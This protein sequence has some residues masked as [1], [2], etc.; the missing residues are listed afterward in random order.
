VFLKVSDKVVF[1]E[2]DDKIVLI[3]LDTGFYYSLNEV[4]RL[5]FNEIL[6]SK[7]VV[8]IVHEIRNAYEV[9]EREAREDLQEFLQSLRAEKIIVQ[10]R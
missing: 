1:R 7:E 9:P 8:D 6:K 10:Q 4:G 5:I 2:I 3:N